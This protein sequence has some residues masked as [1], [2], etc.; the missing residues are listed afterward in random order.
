MSAVAEA[1]PDRH[2]SSGGPLSGA[3]QEAVRW[4]TCFVVAVALHGIVAYYVLEQLSETAEDFSVDTPVV[5]LDLPES[6][7]P[8]IVPQQALPPGPLEPE[9]E[10]TP[11]KE[12]ETKPPEPVAEVAP[13]RPEPPKLEPQQAEVVLP[14]PEPPPKPDESPPPA[15][16]PTAPQATRTPPP[17]VI[18][19]QSQLR[20][21]IEGFKRYPQAARGEGGIATVA[22]TINHDGHLLRSNVVQSSGSAALDQ[23]TL[24]M[25]VRAQPMPRPPDELTDD[26]LTFTIPVRFS[27]R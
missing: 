6:F 27:M 26:A 23:E 1:A 18:R 16:T 9:V 4:I 13:P 17:S 5:M 25:L 19:W 7:V 10:T 20:A 21:H 3:A 24:A 11:P 2:P 8:S 15:P 22:F 14:K 12:E